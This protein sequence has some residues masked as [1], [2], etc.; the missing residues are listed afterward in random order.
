VWNRYWTYPD[1]RSKPL[2]RQF[3][4]FFVVNVSGIVIRAPLIAVTH[5]PLARLTARVVPALA[6]G[7]ARW[8]KNLALG[9]A[10]GIVMFWNF[11]VN[12]YWTYSDV[13]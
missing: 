1:S 12:R 11:F 4:Q 7:A 8:G 5:Q 2:A 10:V 6:D 13:D 9:L 3:G